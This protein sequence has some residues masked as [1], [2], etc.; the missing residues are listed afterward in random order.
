MFYNGKEWILACDENGGILPGG[1]GWMV[2]GSR[3]DYINGDPSTIEIQVYHFSAVQ[4]AVN[5]STTLILDDEEDIVE[6]VEEK[7]DVVDNVQR[8]A[9]GGSGGG[10]FIGTATAFDSISNKGLHTNQGSE[11]PYFSTISVLAAALALALIGR[12]RAV[13]CVCIKVKS[14]RTRNGKRMMK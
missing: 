1:E 7:V 8:G 14:D 9:T 6:E 11:N 12:L 4:A 3:I 5:A 10:C 2:P 13:E